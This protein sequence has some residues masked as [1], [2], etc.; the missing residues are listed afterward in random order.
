MASSRPKISVFIATSL[1]GYIARENG[2]L[3][4]LDSIPNEEGLDYGF[5]A[6]LDSVDTLILGRNTYDVVSEFDTWPYQGKRVIVLSQNLK[7]V[8]GEAELFAGSCESLITKLSAEGTTH[9]YVDGGKTIST[10]LEKNL[11]DAVTIT[12]IPTLLGTGIRLF[13]PMKTEHSCQ[14]IA[15]KSYPNGLVQVTY[16][17]NHLL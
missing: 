17:I 8:R 11:V 6:F 5:K 3:D 15:S 2:A 14:L 10:F 16:K 12:L 7:E 9:I 13:S 1:D 4:W